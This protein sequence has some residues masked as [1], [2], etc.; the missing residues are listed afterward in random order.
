MT[1]SRRDFLKYCTAAAAAL[2]LSSLDLGLLQTALAAPG[3]PNILWLHG[4][5]CTGC[6]VSLLN[7]VAASAPVSVADLLQTSVNLVYHVTLMG[8]SGELAV[9]AAEKAASGDYIL[10]VEGAVPTAFHG[11]A[12]WVWKRKGKHVTL[13]QAVKELSAKASHVVCAGTCASYGGV[14]AAGENPGRAKSVQAI[15]GRTTINVSGCPA[16][17]DWIIFVLAQLLAG[18][19]V[20]TDSCGRPT[21]IYDSSVHLQCD[22]RHADKATALG[23]DGLCLRDLGCRGPD[24]CATCPELKWNNGQNWC[25]DANSPCI[26]CTSPEFPFKSFR[27]TS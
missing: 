19:K 8:A 12:C 17:P 20:E 14:S 11:Q 13:L 15:T 18:K 16:H 4:S 3:A 24:T 5:G 25:V 1:I 2:G 22:R 21:A 10:V 7:R 23:Q 9:E 26:G 6:S 27:A